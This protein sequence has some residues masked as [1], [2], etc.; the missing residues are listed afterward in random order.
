VVIGAGIGYAL[1]STSNDRVKSPNRTYGG[2]K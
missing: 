2:S 1:Y